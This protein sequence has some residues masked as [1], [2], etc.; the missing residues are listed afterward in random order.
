MST[1]G[2]HIEIKKDLSRFEDSYYDF[3]PIDY[4]GLPITVTSFKPYSVPTRSNLLFI[5]IDPLQDVDKKVRKQYYVMVDT[6][7]LVALECLIEGDAN[8][9]FNKIFFVDSY[10]FLG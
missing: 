7:S 4:D 1:K 8:N 6:E 2:A 10:R 9:C 3:I 5:V